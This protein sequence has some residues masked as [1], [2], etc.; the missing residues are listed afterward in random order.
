ML[1]Q[2]QRHKLAHHELLA[3]KIEESLVVVR[4][5]FVNQ[6]VLL[7]WEKSRRILKWIPIFTTKPSKIRMSHFD[8]R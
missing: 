5:L 8:S 2:Y 1:V 7:V 4:G 3:H 6:S